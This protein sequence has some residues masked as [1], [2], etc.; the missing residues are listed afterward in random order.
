MDLT[1][2]ANDDKIL[3]VRFYID[4][5]GALRLFILVTVFSQVQ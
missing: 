2:F 3:P 1:Y 4:A 5:L